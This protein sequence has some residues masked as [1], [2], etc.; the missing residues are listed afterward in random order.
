MAA[1]TTS[2]E[3]VD[4]THLLDERFRLTSGRLLARNTIWNLAGQVL[5]MAAGLVAVPPLVHAMGVPRF[6][7]FSLAWIVIGYFSLFDLGIGRALTKL[8]ADRIGGNDETS[9]S[10]LVWTSLALMCLLGVFGGI[11]MLVISPWLVR[12]ALNIPQ[13]L[14]GE[15]LQS[16]YLL[17]IAIP[18]T[19]TTS[20]LRGTLEAQQQF[21]ILNVIRIPMG[22]FSFVGPLLILPFSHSLVAAVSVL[23]AGRFGGCAAHM[24]ACFRSMPSLRHGFALKSS[25]VAP[26][27]KFGGWMAV[28]NFIS[29]LMVYLDRFVI[30][31]LLSMGTVAYYTAPFDV[32]TRLT[33]IPSALAGVLFPAL[34]MSLLDDRSRTSLLTRRGVKYVFVAIFPIVMFAVALA[35]ELLH[36]WLGTD[37]A[38]NSSAVLRWLAAG[39][40]LNC[41]A[42]VPFALIQGAGRPDLTGKLHL[43]ELPVYLIALFFL[44]RSNGIVGASIAWAGRAA[45]DALLLFVFAQELLPQASRYWL[46]QAAVVVAAMVLLYLTTLP[47]ALTTRAT[48]LV[49]SGVMFGLAM[50]SWGLDSGER[51][52]LLRQKREA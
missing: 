10:P 11:V 47:E 50:W 25:L 52:S 20:G 19:T 38:V 42:Y 12:Q 32:A 51:I 49:F 37:F 21:R 30:G 6:G 36:V 29:P 44:V 26:V 28:S 43:L 40:L 14:Q 2:E 41:L 22:I 17:A 13:T 27:L 8:V 5:P 3:R 1:A 9:I 4:T 35:P 33:I 34:A 31:A 16:F 7:V 45:L 24:L 18:A 15:A 48:V 39:V 46:K 23:I